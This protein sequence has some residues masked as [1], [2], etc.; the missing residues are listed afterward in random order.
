MLVLIGATLGAGYQRGFMACNSHLID[1]KRGKYFQLRDQTV[2]PIKT[3]IKYF[4]IDITIPYL[5]Y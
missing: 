5:M 1:S 2:A 4:T 3:N